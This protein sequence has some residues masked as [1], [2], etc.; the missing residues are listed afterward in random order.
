MAVATTGHVDPSSDDLLHFLFNNDD[1]I[2][3]QDGGFNPAEDGL[4]LP[5]LGLVRKHCKLVLVNFM[6]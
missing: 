3:T 2:L 5:D 1:G 4:Q 6:I